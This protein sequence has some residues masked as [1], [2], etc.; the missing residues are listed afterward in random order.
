LSDDLIAPL[1]GARHFLFIVTPLG[2]N[3]YLK[4][5]DHVCT[6]LDVNFSKYV[7]PCFLETLLIT[8]FCASALIGSQ[9]FAD[10][11]L[12]TLEFVYLDALFGYNQS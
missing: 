3:N 10:L 12:G 2:E 9:V 8:Q 1:L 11:D 4:T 5:L 6:I 7:S